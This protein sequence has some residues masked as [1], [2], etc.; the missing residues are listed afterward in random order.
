MFRSVFNNKFN[1]VNSIPIFIY[2]G[3][4]ISYHNFTPEKGKELLSLSSL[5]P[6]EGMVINKTHYVSI[7]KAI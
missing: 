1:N 3:I 6:N 2:N 5:M 4:F 7:T